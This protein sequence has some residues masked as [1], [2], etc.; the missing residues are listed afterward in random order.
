MHF[1]VNNAYEDGSDT[2]V[3]LVQWDLDW[4]ELNPQLRDF[5][6]ADGLSFGGHLTRL[7][8]TAD[9]RVL[10]ERLSDAAGEFPQFD[11]RLTGR[12]H[13][14]SYLAARAGGNASPNAVVK[15]DH[16]IGGEQAHVLPDG[17]AVSEPIFV[18]RTT[19]AGED[20]GWLFAVAYDP[21]EH[22]SRLLV[23]D[24]RDPERAPL[25]TGHLRHHLPQS[26][27]GTFTRRVAD[28]DK[29]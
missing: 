21:I 25:Y 19:D 12:P 24:A 20:D 29:A 8:I 7:R 3:D 2:V 27:H 11:W 18:P 23:L 22:R 17:H 14:Y 9:G 26:F 5:R 15:T 16:Q 6:T 10:R 1:H 13:R 4:N 28:P